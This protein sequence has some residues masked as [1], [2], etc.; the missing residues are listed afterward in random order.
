MSERP[1]LAITMGD[2]AGI[3]P[4]ITLKALADATLYDESRP[5]VIGSLAALEDIRARLDIPVSLRRVSA[6]S[7]ASYTAGTVDVLD[8]D[9]IDVSKLT[10]GEVQAQC[11]QAAFEYV[12]RAVE[13]ANAGQVDAVVTAPINKEALRAANV[14]YIGHTEMFADL[15]HVKSEMTMFLIQNVRIFFLTRHVPLIEACRQIADSDF[16]HAGI[17]R[18]YRALATL[19]AAKPRLAVAGLNPHSGEG[20]LL[21]REEIES[22]RPAIERAVAQGMDVVGPV[23]ADSVFHFARQG[24]YDAVLSL[25][26][27]QGHIAAKVMDFEKTVSIT[28]GLPTLRTSVDHGTAFDIAGKGLASAVSMVEAIRAAIRYAPN[29]RPV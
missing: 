11:G 8:L 29:Y 21:G 6:P 3:G 25:Y 12:Q 17:V 19:A 26:H 18:A 15:Q 23:P 10:L 28:L 5:L 7:E 16:V 20:G 13:L 2:A 27:D 9:N 1:V 4:E 22:I 14:P 24:Q